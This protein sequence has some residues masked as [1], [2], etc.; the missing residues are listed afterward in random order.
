MSEASDRTTVP[1]TAG[2]LLAALGACAVL[3]LVAL[4][5]G[6]VPRYEARF[7]ELGVALPQLTILAIA[8]GR[9]LSAGGWLLAVLLAAVP[10]GIAI[11]DRRSALGAIVGIATLLLALAI[12]GLGWLALELP[13]RKIQEQQAAPP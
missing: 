13:L 7:K 12:G 3:A 4:A 6:V 5:V 9:F 11:A 8:L 10:V 2:L 1:G